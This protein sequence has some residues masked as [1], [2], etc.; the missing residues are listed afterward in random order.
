MEEMNMETRKV[1]GI[2]RRSDITFHSDGRIDITA[3]VAKA[4]GMHGGDV[5]NIAEVSDH[6]TER[7]LYV[8]RR[9][10]ETTGRHCGTCRPVKH[11]G[12][13]LRTYSRQLTRYALRKAGGASSISFRVGVAEEVEGLGTALPLI[14]I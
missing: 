1:I 2:T 10:G 12:N 8:A 9:S 6:F 13:Y 11:N 7:Y 3:H 4:L 14:G 5:I